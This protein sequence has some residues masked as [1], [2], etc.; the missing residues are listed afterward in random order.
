MGLKALGRNSYVYLPRRVNGRGRISIGSNTTVSPH[1][2]IEAIHEYLGVQ[3]N[4]SIRIGD[5]VYVGGY[6]CIQSAL[7]IEIQ[8]DCVLSEY[9]YIADQAHGNMPDRG[10]L[11]NQPLEVKG[12]VVIGKGTFLGYRASVLPGVV[13]GQYCVVGAN[14]VVTKSFPAYTMIAGCPARQVKVFSHAARR[15]VASETAPPT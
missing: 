10:S 11:M 1:A 13:L 6:C 7:E 4:P 14:S 12:K 8:D 15:W 9:V 3:H 5:N 2:W